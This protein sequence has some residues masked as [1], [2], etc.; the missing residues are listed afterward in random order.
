MN[1]AMPVVADNNTTEG[2][3]KNRRIEAN[4]DCAIIKK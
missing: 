4:F 1:Y 2:R 3:Q